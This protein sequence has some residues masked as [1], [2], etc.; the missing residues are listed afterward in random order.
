MRWR[1][2]FFL[3]RGALLPGHGNFTNVLQVKTKAWYRTCITGI[4]AGS[5]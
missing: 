3:W 1:G 5:A 2:H 4:C